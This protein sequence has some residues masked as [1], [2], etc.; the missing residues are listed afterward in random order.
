MDLNACDFETGMSCLQRSN[1]CS[2]NA[3]L[4]SRGRR[5]LLTRLLRMQ[6]KQRAIGGRQD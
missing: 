5:R 2:I 4:R 6:K 3:V 1:D